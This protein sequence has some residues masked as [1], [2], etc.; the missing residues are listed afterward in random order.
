MHEAEDVAQLVR[1]ND[2]EFLLVGKLGG[3]ACAS[4][5]PAGGGLLQR[6]ERVEL[7]GQKLFSNEYS[8]PLSAK[9]RSLFRSALVCASTLAHVSVALDG[10]PR[11]PASQVPGLN[12]SVWCASSA[13]ASATRGTI[14]F[15]TC[16]CTR[17]R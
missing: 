17:T 8:T 14:L 2:L 7:S 9:E 5:R 4:L 6:V 15:R 3:S 1:Q 10:W 13:R 12:A 11:T 16:T